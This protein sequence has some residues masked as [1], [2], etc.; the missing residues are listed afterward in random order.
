MLSSCSRLWR[1]GPRTFG[2]ASVFRGVRRPPII[3][4]AG[5][6]A[7][8]RAGH[9]LPVHYSTHPVSCRGHDSFLAGAEHHGLTPPLDGVLHRRWYP[10]RPIPLHRGLRPHAQRTSRAA[11]AIAPNIRPRPAVRAIWAICRAPAHFRQ[12][13]V[14]DCR[15]LPS[16]KFR[17]IL[18][19]LATS[20]AAIGTPFAPRPISFL[21]NHFEQL[22]A[23]KG[24]YRCPVSRVQ[25]L[26]LRPVTVNPSFASRTNRASG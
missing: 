20:S 24:R 4:W 21:N 2:L 25:R 3:H 1:Q 5:H 14:E 8:L 17:R 13:Y 15:T 11:P 16:Y 9:V 18:W 6:F 12:L 23:R 7:R 19:A 26:M 10:N 22:A